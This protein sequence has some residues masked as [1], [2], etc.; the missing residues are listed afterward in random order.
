MDEN[1]EEQSEEPLVIFHMPALVS[2][3][4]LLEKRKGSPLSEE[5]VIAAR[6]SA[7]AMALPASEARAIEDAQGFRDLDRDQTW[8]EWQAYRQANSLDL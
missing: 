8:E 5:E 1:Y 6:D 7:P 3:L 4:T 2:V